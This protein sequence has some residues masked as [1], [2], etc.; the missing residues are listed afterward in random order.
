MNKFFSARVK[1]ILIAALVIAIL[2]GVTALIRSE[3]TFAG[4]AVNGLLQP[5]RSAMTAIARQV[6][7]F[8][9]YI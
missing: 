3:A 7:S 1:G 2:C 9:N 4:N 5:V 8:Y 6:E